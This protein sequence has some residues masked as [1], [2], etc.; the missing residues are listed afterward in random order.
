[1]FD[2]PG[3]ISPASLSG[4]QDEIGRLVNRFWHGGMSMPPLDGQDWAPPWDVYELPDRYVARVDIPGLD[5]ADI[6]VTCTEKTLSIKGERPVDKDIEELGAVYLWQ[7]RRTGKFCRTIQLPE[8]ID[9]DR[10]AATCRS[11]RLEVVL[12]KKVDTTQIGRKI[13]VNEG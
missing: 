4:L 9:E 1:M 11:G 13:E 10:I 6:D 3:R 7:E 5:P 2:V 12:P 8:A